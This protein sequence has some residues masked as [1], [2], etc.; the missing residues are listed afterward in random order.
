METRA[1]ESFIKNLR[2]K[3]H[4]ENVFIFPRINFG[5][6]LALFWKYGVDLHVLDSFL[7]YI[8]AVVNPGVDDAWRFTSF[9]KTW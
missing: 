2:N 7:T 5:G 9:T 6:G 1:K 4:L 3:L 8:D